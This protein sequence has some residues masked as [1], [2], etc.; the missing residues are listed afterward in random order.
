MLDRHSQRRQAHTGALAVISRRLIS[1]AGDPCQ[2]PPTI[3]SR[4]N[5]GGGK[6]PVDAAP[7]TTTDAQGRV[8]A[9]KPSASLET[10]LFDRLL[11]MHGD[12]IK[13]T[14]TVQYRCAHSVRLN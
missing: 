11:S 7:A 10:T 13:R 12:R 6:A 14:L 5:K 9:L 8:L 4:G 2:L 3:K 1:Q